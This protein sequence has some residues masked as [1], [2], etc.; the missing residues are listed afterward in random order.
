MRAKIQ[1][2]YHVFLGEEKNYYSVPWQYVGE[3]AEVVY[4][5]MVV[6]VYLK[7][8]RIAIH[9]RL[10]GRGTHFYQTEKS[11]MPRHHQE[12]EKAQGQDAVHF[13]AQA[14]KIGPATRWAIQSILL[15]RIFQEQTYNSCRGVLRLGSKYGNPR[16]E[17]ACERCR[18]ADKANYSMLQRILSLRLDEAEAPPEA[19]D[20]GVH[21]NIRGAQAYQ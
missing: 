15:S 21:E 3:Q 9:R 7:G 10:P 6:E 2:N 13:L 5:A 14:E 18:Q 12:W 8:K 17:K 11:H 4:T 20:L 16:L 1:W 19:P